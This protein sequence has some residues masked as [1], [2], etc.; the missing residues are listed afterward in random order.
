MTWLTVL[1]KPIYRTAM[2]TRLTTLEE[3]LAERIYY[4]PRTR[5]LKGKR[6]LL[7]QDQTEI[8]VTELL[9][10][11]ETD[12]TTVTEAITTREAAITPSKGEAT[13][14]V[15]TLGITIALDRAA[16]AA[17]TEDTRS[18]ATAERE[19]TSAAGRGG[20]ATTTAGET[21]SG[22]TEATDT[23]VQAITTIAA[24]GSGT[25]TTRRRRGRARTTA[26]RTGSWSRPRRKQNFIRNV[27]MA[28]ESLST[29]NKLALWSDYYAYKYHHIV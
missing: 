26:G 20:E 16:T 5:S 10:T 19:T 28:L 4:Q 15:E 12:G 17:D 24:A 27:G 18:E 21:E 13:Q 29:T 23:T 9:R 2:Q 14:Q 8:Q 7:R 25:V 1:A 3:A 11:T 22:E 6:E